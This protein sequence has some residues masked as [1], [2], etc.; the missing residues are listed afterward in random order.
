M[1]A[2]EFQ[3]L[4]P[5][6]LVRHWPLVGR[7][8]ELRFTIQSITPPRRGLVLVGGPGVGK[9]RLA[10][11]AAEQ[12]KGAGRIV[13]SVAATEA[14]RGRAMGALSHAFG[15]ELAG[16]GPSGATELP[17]VLRRRGGPVEPLI[18]LDDAHQLDDL[19]ASILYQWSTAG[20]AIV[21]ATARRG[22]VLPEPIT[23]LYKDDQVERLDLQPL[24]RAEVSQLLEAVLGGQLADATLSGLWQASAGNVLYLKEL[25]LDA[26]DA[27][28]LSDQ[29]DVWVWSGGAGPAARLTEVIGSRLAGL[30]ADE[31]AAMEALA[32]AGPLDASFLE[33]SAGPDHVVALERAG[34][35]EIVAMG[36]RSEIHLAH[37]LHGEVLRAGVGEYRRRSIL[38]GLAE[39]LEATGH[40]RSEDLLR[41][42]RWRVAS[43]TASDAGR[44]VLAAAEANRMHDSSNAELLARCA[45]ELKPSP[46]A[47]LQLG[48]ALVDQG[49]NEE[50]EQVLSGVAAGELDDTGR[51]VLAYQRMRALFY[52]LGRM[53]QADQALNTI[54]SLTAA[55]DIRLTVRGWRAMVLS[56]GGRTR[57][58]ADLWM[59]LLE[60]GSS[61][62]REHAL[63]NVALARLMAGRIGEAAT[64][65]DKFLDPER[66]EGETPR[67]VKALQIL[68]LGNEGRIADATVMAEALTTA[69]E[70]GRQRPGE[71]A[72]IDT[73]KG[74]LLLMAGKPRSARRALRQAAVVLRRHDA[75]GF[76]AWCVSLQIEAA[77]LLGDHAAVQALLSETTALDGSAGVTIFQ[78]GA[79]RAQAWG[80]VAAGDADAATVRLTTLATDLEGR[81]EIMEAVR[82]LHDAVRLGAPA[83]PRLADLVRRV[84]GGLG[85]LIAAHAEGLVAGD[86]A[87]VEQAAAGLASAGCTLMAVD[88]ELQAAGLW[89]SVGRARRAAAARERADGLAHCCEGGVTPA[90]ARANAPAGLTHREDQVA[91]LA[92]AGLANKEIAARLSTSV[93]TIEGHLQQVYMKL[94][95][96]SRSALA[97]TLF[98]RGPNHGDFG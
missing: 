8:E 25:V 48:A 94:G 17:E 96:T 83:A 69:M 46:E 72:L 49:R 82:C 42:A 19:S 97:G 57:E 29:G 98:R 38:K 20:L 22:E 40:R 62:A 67:L 52:G 28:S 54:E 34:L 91:R 33:E 95:I 73:V 50:A 26:V 86:A 35:V 81:G 14:T 63:P 71:V 6:R 9:T 90:M 65:I 12:A 18:V 55:E 84:D 68:V 60:S 10:K 30:G 77:T 76:L 47:A 11:E 79:Q 2:A 39:R 31:L 27:G 75:G 1:A 51:K 85:S 4:A 92:G 64:L 59:E 87:A 61:S 36:R 80:M 21:L 32:V 37:P 53:E 23:A 13:V 24:S 44:L 78:G 15:R 16:I 66:S 3:R 88:A 93:R 5:P 7:V 70:I 58:A 43:G 45:L 74:H 89:A 56:H 41:L